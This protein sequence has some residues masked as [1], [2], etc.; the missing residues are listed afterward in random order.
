MLDEL[1]F[2]QGAVGKKDMVP[3][4]THYRIRNLGITSF[5]GTIALSSPFPMD[6]DCIPK[7]LPMYKAIQ[8]CNTEVMTLKLTPKGRL[9]IKSGPFKAFVD[10]LPLETELPEILPEGVKIDID[11]ERFLE[12]LK[13]VEPFIGADASR[14]WSNGVLLSGCS[15]F[16]T[17]NIALVEYWTGVEYNNPINIPIVAI[18][19]LLRIKEPP[20]Q[21]QVAENSATFHYEN[22][23]WLRTSLLE[24]KWPDLRKI[25][26]VQSN[27]TPI[28]QTLFEGLSYLKPFCDDLNRIYLLD[29][30]L[31]TSIIEGEGAHFDIDNFPYKGVYQLPMLELLATATH[32]DFTAYPKP[33]LFFGENIRG[34]IIGM[35][36]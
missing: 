13:A 6:I 7:A 20:F 8:S 22:N 18:K 24:T 14:P 23:K 28:N 5:N 27:A 19:E 16:A 10:C 26:D 11:G 35:K 29:G 36:A 4:L 33:V 9:S 1:K 17:N 34:A 32:A 30:T 21:I 12:A 3:A 25:L 2:V 15:M 31:A